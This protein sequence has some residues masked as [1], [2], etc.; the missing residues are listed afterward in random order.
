M[1]LI[2]YKVRVT[3]TL[4]MFTYLRTTAKV[5]IIDLITPKNPA[6]DLDKKY[7]KRQVGAEKTSHIDST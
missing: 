1:N 5:S 6:P 2:E 7:D 3:N 4:R